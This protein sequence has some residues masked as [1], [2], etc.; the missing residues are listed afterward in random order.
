MERGVCWMNSFWVCVDRGKRN[1][2]GYEGV[3]ICDVGVVVYDK[4]VDRE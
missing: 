3:D 2:G 1:G 4:V